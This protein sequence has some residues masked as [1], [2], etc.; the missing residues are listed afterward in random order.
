MLIALSEKSKSNNFEVSSYPSQ[1]GKHQTKQQTRNAGEDLSEG[2]FFTASLL[3]GLKTAKALW[4]QVW[5]I[6]KAKNKWIVLSSSTTLGHL[7]KGRLLS[8]SALS[9]LLCSQ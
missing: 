3:V 8:C 2:A 6:K 5:K 4:K 1:N 7:P 9:R